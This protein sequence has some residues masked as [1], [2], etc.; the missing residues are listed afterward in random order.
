MKIIQNEKGYALLLTFI[1]IILI[2][3]LTM[4]FSLRALN[5]NRLVEKTDMSYEAT[6][7]AEMGVEYY[8]ARVLNIIEKYQTPH[9]REW[10]SVNDELG[11]LNDYINSTL[12]SERG[13]EAYKRNIQSYIDKALGYL[14]MEIGNFFISMLK[15]EISG[16]QFE[17]SNV[18]SSSA[19]WK[20]EITGSSKEDNQVIYVEFYLKDSKDNDFELIILDPNGGTINPSLPSVNITGITFNNLIPRRTNITN[21]AVNVNP[22]TTFT[23]DDFILNNNLENPNNARIQSKGSVAING[24]NNMTSL[25]IYALGN[26]TIKNAIHAKNLN[27][28][29]NTLNMATLNSLNDSK[30]EIESTAAFGAMGNPV[31]NSKIQVNGKATFDYFNNITNQSSIKINGATEFKYISMMEKGSEFL[32]NGKLT[33]SEYIQNI[34]DGSLIKVMGDANFGKYIDGT[35]NSKIHVAG[36]VDV[37]YL[38]NIKNNSELLI[39][40]SVNIS[41]Y[42]QTM[43]NSKV[44]VGGAMTVGYINSL[45]S[46]SSLTINGEADF[47]AHIESIEEGS[48]VKVGGNATVGKVIMR[49]GHMNIE[50]QL[51]IN[52]QNPTVIS[53]G[54]IVV[55]SVNFSGDAIGK[56]ESISVEGNGKLCVRDFNNTSIALAEKKSKATGQ[57]KIIFLNNKRP[58]DYNGQISLNSLDTGSHTRE[59]GIETFNSLCGVTSSMPTDNYIINTIP[60]SANS[61]TKAIEYY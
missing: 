24:I 7:V 6:A 33:T 23:G 21:L 59:V 28:Y 60:P 5:H 34:N 41:E 27:L 29:A 45:K 55:T 47:G 36:N 18:L 53:G 57:G 50:G 13:T 16:T 40:G 31:N 52:G 61:I 4:S 10:E 46:G 1:T 39:K 20:I 35:S 51:M 42:I 38:Q 17:I 14:E 32:I 2:V 9:T 8:Q 26:V 58:K 43:E 44:H 49:D 11:Y 37:G 56:K 25:D 22:N 30:I 15:K 3:I 12:P 54:T 48:T 19:P